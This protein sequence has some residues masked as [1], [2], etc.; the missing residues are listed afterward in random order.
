[1]SKTLGT[2]LTVVA[3]GVAIASGV[4]ALAAGT[5]ALISAGI[6]AAQFVNSAVLASR[7]KD[8][9][10][11]R[12][13]SVAALQLGE[14]AR[15]GIFGE[16]LTGGSLVDAFN[17][18]GQ[19]GTD[20][21]CRIIALAD[22]LC[23][24]L[25]GFYV[26]DVF[27]KYTG[28]GAVPGYNGQLEVYWR[29]GGVV[30][31]VPQVVLA[32]AP[33]WTAND[34]GSG[35]AWVAVCYKADK[36]DA[37]NPVWPGGRPGFS[38]VVR[39]KRC[40]QARK[41]STAGGSGTHRWSD[42]STWEWTDNPIDCRHNW[43]RGI[44]AGDRVGDP[45]MLL[46][47]RGLSAEEA[48]PA[49]VFGPANVCDEQVALDA[50]GSEK[51]YRLNGL[52][53]ADETY[54]EVE[55]HFAA[56]CAGVILQPEGAVEIEPGQAK[57]PSFFFS[58]EDLLVGSSVEY[59]DELSEADNGWVN[60]V[61]PR[62]VEPKLKYADHA[63]PIRRVVA[64]V[65]ADGGPREQPLSL[66]MVTSSTQAG[67]VGEIARRMGRLRR[68]G[69]VTLGPAFAEVEEGDWGVWTSERYLKGKSVLFRVEAYALD[70]KWH[71]T[72]TLRE[73]SRDVYAKDADA[74]S[75]AVAIRQDAP[76][77][78]APGATAWTAAPIVTGSNGRS[79]PAIAVTGQVDSDYAELVRFEYC[80][81][82]AGG[83]PA[84]ARWIEA[85][86]AG[87]DARRFEITGVAAS[88]GYAVAVSYVVGRVPGAR[89]VLPTVTTMAASVGW[90]D[91]AD[92][93]G[94]RPENNATNSRDPD[95]PFGT[96]TVGGTV[97]R[98]AEIGD[99]M[100]KVRQEV[101][102]A[103]GLTQAAIA[104]RDAARV[105]ATNAATARDDSRT[106][107]DAAQ[108]ASGDALAS[109]GAAA[110]SAGAA[111]RQATI[112]TTKATT[113]TEQAS[114]ASAQ[115]TLATTKAGD[116]STSASSAAT[117]ERAASGSATAAA[118][119]ARV[120]A[121][122]SQAAATRSLVTKGD[123]ADGDAGRWRFSFGQNGQIDS[124]LLQPA[125]HGQPVPPNGSAFVLHL[126]GAR[127]SF[128]GT[129]DKADPVNGGWIRGAWGGRKLRFTGLASGQYSAF[130]GNVGV[131][132]D[133]P[134]GQRYYMHGRACRAGVAGYE[135]FDFVLEMP[136]GTTEIIPWVQN[137][138][139][140]GD[141]TAQ[142]RLAS[143]RIEDVTDRAA[144][145]AAASAAAES[146]SSAAT[147]KTAAGERAS[148]A[149]SARTEAITAAGKAATYRDQASTS[150]TGAS[151]SAVLASIAA[152]VAASSATGNL[153]KHGDFSDGSSGYWPIGPYET[154]M[155][156][157]RDYGHTPPPG[158]DWVYLV[159]GF[160]DVL[161]EH[162]WN[163]GAGNGPRDG[164]RIAGDWG[165]RIIRVE[166]LASAEF[167]PH[168][169]ACGY[170]GYGADGS[171]LQF[172]GVIAARAG[173][174]GYSSVKSD[175]VVS[176]GVVKIVPW[177]QNNGPPGFETQEGRW[178]RFSLRDVT[179]E[180]R[181]GQSASAAAGSA[182]T[183]GTR[184]D[185]AGRSATAAQ[186]AYTNA[187]ASNRGAA[188]SAQSAAGSASSASR[189][190]SSALSYSE[191]AA[192]Y[193]SSAN[194]ASANAKS[195]YEA[196]VGATG[197]LSEKVDTLRSEYNQTAADLR[198][199]SSV[200]SDAYGRSRAFLQQKAVAGNNR[201]Q[202]TFY[203]DSNGGAGVDLVGDLSVSGDVV[204]GGTLRARAFDKSSMSR[205]GR[206]TWSGSTTPAGGQE[207]QLPGL[208]LPSVP[209]VGRFL[210]EFS[211]AVSTNA[212]Q[213]QVSTR[214]NKPA[215]LDF[216]ADGG[217]RVRA[218]DGQGNQYSPRMAGTSTELIRAA[219]DFT[220]N[221]AVWVFAGN[222]D[223]G[224]IDDGDYY[225]RVMSATY[226]V[227]SYD[228]RVLWLA[229]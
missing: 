98:I 201:A 109:A 15:E 116:A 221:F 205:D 93:N 210:Y 1:M 223:T 78:G 181:A 26:N 165:G 70:E 140:N 39:G 139:A 124:Y 188:T 31:T 37:K 198:T 212:G 178:A 54:I 95:S 224:W 155:I 88:T 199:V 190:A 200:A 147:S 160:R 150:A 81:A 136:A 28:E 117:S 179:E 211:S 180:V 43:V 105:A 157:P 163:G 185:D 167:S 69:K 148:A 226:T 33:G 82:D 158:Q 41:D 166:A 132:A 186:T 159:R 119:Q 30:Q 51:R 129:L 141:L 128:E 38:W 4:G 99:L 56:A 225:R 142:V 18:G 52:V 72:L 6:A 112:A 215:Y 170:F 12:Q 55:D 171:V 102:G 196:T 113:A 151:G 222:Y 32:N 13:A 14:V 64:D 5:A 94:T 220:P 184:A 77:I 20:W 118:T 120:A 73:I 137:P 149:E 114:I 153:V 59:S 162:G 206:T 42:P 143:F 97:K 183:A 125:A 135:P 65:L 61:A 107:R 110:G 80:V 177:L 101:S 86:F 134:N 24:G 202:L 123:F 204:I 173:V 131:F 8:A 92:T 22:H 96:G 127:D 53:R 126:R 227:T 197:S 29:A 182:T 36:A 216:Q 40:Y 209:P 108:K 193:S 133:G 79:M 214:N 208:G 17:W 172:G 46:V 47:G 3:I 66:T 27:E 71:N 207:I 57:A 75:T 11:K 34:F 174:A 194:T 195:H 219:T 58:D 45:D 100:D 35:V 138:S 191:Q 168:D 187:E 228:L 189:D 91:I 218:I 175:L 89:R 68:R 229:I 63:A 104:A 25:T 87:P 19:W 67:R 203:A 7:A 44:Y 74:A 106:A 23:D 49:N 103:D 85:G 16:V 111:E 76:S 62:Y 213:R 48:P 152:T 122:S 90:T 176:A 50:G 10:Q 84:N 21:E 2:I 83:P 9:L 60:T 192:R 161:E 145:E 169:A 130:D 146:A 115:A 217:L 121:Q 156:R 144:T 154:R 164:G